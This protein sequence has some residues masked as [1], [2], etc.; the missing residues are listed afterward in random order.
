MIYKKVS[1]DRLKML[2]RCIRVMSMEFLL[3]V[4]NNIEYII[5]T[6]SRYFKEK[7]QESQSSQYTYFSKN[8]VLDYAD[9]F[10]IPDSDKVYDEIMLSKNDIPISIP[11]HDVMSLICELVSLHLENII[12]LMNKKM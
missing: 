3:D 10:G 2:K 4:T 9:K 12:F 5:N 1:F 6:L 8:D 7:L 11:I